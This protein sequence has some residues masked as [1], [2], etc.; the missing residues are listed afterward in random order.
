MSDRVL[1]ARPDLHHY[2]KEAKVLL[3]ACRNA[4]L[5]ALD[6]L[7]RHHPRSPEAA[8][9]KL[10]D[11][12][13]VIAREHD[14]ESWPKFAKHIQSFPE[15][16]DA[17]IAVEGVELIAEVSDTKNAAGLVLFV[18][19]SGT[20]RFNP[21]NQY[22]VHELQRAGFCTVSVDL[23]TEDEEVADVFSEEFRF[24][25][26][27]LAARIV[28]ITDWIGGQARFSNLPLA[29]MA[30]D[31][32]VPAALIAAGD[33]P[34]NVRALVSNMGRPDLAGPW[35]WKVKAPTLLVVA[36]TDTVGLGF[37]RSVLEAFSRETECG[38]EVIDGEVANAASLAIDWFRRYVKS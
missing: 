32:A 27:R 18:H 19:A 26:R 14:F 28:T 9:L 24:D 11:A 21:R 10:A 36:E 34:R 15:S 38:F 13:L 33:R 31:T 4:N 7:R 1:P 17:R 5:T 22:V 12:Q 35:L 2:K 16:N 20:A 6:R 30:S 25:I 23:M 29:Y 37:N 8:S 3:G